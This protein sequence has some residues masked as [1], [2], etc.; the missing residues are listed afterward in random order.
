M[1]WRVVF[2]LAA[3]EEPLTIFERIARQHGTSSVAVVL[4]I[5]RAKVD[6]N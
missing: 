1:S 2:P 6:G 5:E 3:K 4:H